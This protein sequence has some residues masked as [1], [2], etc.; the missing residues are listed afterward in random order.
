[1]YTSNNTI[2]KILEIFPD[3]ENSWAE[4]LR[5]WQGDESREVGIDIISFLGFVSD[6]L[7]NNEAYDYKKVFDLIETFLIEGDEE[8]IYAFEMNFLE[9][10]L[11]RS[12]HGNFPVDS[13]FPYLG[14]ES[15][16]FC[17]ANEEF[18]GIENSKFYKDK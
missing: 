2:N 16:A 9:N 10:L 12:S 5:D 8:I 4:Y 3:F 17:K 13:F 11:N 14:K 15:K 7:S 6:K 18:W 1:M